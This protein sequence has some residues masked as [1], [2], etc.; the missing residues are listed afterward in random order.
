MINRSTKALAAAFPYTIPVF[1]GFLFLGIAYGILMSQKGYGPAWTVAMSLFVFAGSAQYVAI[2]FLTA[3]FDPL[4]AFLMTLMINARHL[5]YGVSML[6]RFRGL[7]AAKPYLIFGM[8]DETFS[9]LCS[10]EA[11]EGVDRRRFMLFVTA[12]DHAYWVAG[13]AI[14]ALL[15]ALVSIRVAGL[16]FVLTALF[17]VIFTGQ[18]KDAGRRRPAVV[19]LAVSAACLVVFGPKG[20]IIPAMI[21]ILATLSLLRA[22]LSEGRRS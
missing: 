2:T 17:L 19:G 3:V 6:G 12:L 11:P 7:G 16:D 1:T 10:T 8:C 22:P 21:A 13:S 14:G 18:V 4:G 20:F 15:G 9:I 5:F